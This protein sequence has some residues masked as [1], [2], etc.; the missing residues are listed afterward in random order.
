MEGMGRCFRGLLGLL[1]NNDDIKRTG[2]M[3][4]SRIAKIMNTFCVPTTQSLNESNTLEFPGVDRGTPS[5][6]T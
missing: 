1:S 5:S 2:G 4:G 3:G 6:L